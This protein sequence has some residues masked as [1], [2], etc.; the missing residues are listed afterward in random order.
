MREPRA[1]AGAPAP[2]GAGAGPKREASAELELEAGAG[3][4]LTLEEALQQASSRGAC[5]L[6]RPSRP[7]ALGPMP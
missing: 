4:V 7:V 1:P 5:S 6:I 2:G 3:A